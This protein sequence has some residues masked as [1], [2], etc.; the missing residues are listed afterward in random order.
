M[1]SWAAAA[2]VQIS[3]QIPFAELPHAITSNC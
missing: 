2:L 3:F 1:P